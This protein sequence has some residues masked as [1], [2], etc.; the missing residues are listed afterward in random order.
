VCRECNEEESG[1]VL[2][3]GAILVSALVASATSAARVSAADGPR[4]LTELSLEELTKIEVTSVSKREEP[5]AEAAAAISVITNESMRRYGARTIPEALRLVPGLHVA[6]I[7]SSAWGVSARGFSSLNSAKLLV[8]SDTR[9]IYTPLFS[10]VFWYVQDFLIEDIDRVEVIRGPGASL[11]GANAVNGVINITSK[12]AKDTQGAYFEGGGGTTERAFG[13]VRFGGQLAPE[14]WFRVFAQGFERTGEFGPPYPAADGWKLGHLGFR[15]DWEPDAKNTLT[16]QGDAYTGD[17]G[18]VRPSI[19]AGGRPGATGKLVLGVAGGNVLARWTRRLASDSEIQVRAY[20]DGTH[21]D[22]PAFVDDLDTV[23][24]EAQH[25]FKLPLGQEVLWGLNY[26]SMDDRTRGKGVFALNPPDSHDNLFSGFVQDQIAV[27][28]SLKVTLGTKLSHNDFS[29]FEVQ[30]TARV[31]WNPFRGQTLWGA[32]SRASRTPTRLERDVDISVTNPAGNPVLKLLGNRAFGSEKLFAYELGY[33]WQIER[34]L[35]IDLAAYYN[36]YK[37]LASLELDPRFVDPQSG[38]TIVPILNKNLTD[39]VAKGGEASITFTPHRSWRLVANYT[40]VLL[41]LE[42]KGQDLNRS[43]LFA[44]S[45]PRNQVEVQSFLDLPA[46]FQLDA[47]F[48]YASALPASS[49][50]VAG[51]DTPAYATVDLRAAWRWGRLELSV[52]GR[53]LA[54]SH[55]REF[56]GG[57]ELERA[58]YAKIAGRF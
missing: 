15:A 25:R 17:I 41:T 3:F 10:G 33:R 28:E 6:Q 48:R 5:L 24:V 35:F 51:E 4:D 29:G 39:G 40:Y 54:Q 57:T 13:A 1:V 36:I 26:R 34:A 18:E 16:F 14:L 49:A 55:H 30:P 20:Y 19:I 53:N 42:P 12:S 44:G 45:T 43:I 9:S 46:S 32:A 2:R 38:K 11:W 47:F 22:D 23:D 27:L 58:F 31:A 52:V 7:T 37:G 8:L 21:H 56:P 50:L